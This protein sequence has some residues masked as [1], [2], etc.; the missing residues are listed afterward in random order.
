MKITGIVVEYNPF[1]NG[2][3]YQIERAR[4]L[5][6]CDYLIVVMSGNFAQR[7]IP[8]IT[9]K[10][11]RTEMALACGVDMVLELPVPFATASA[12]R[13]CE[14]A[15][16]LLHKT[17]IVDTLCFGAEIADLPLMETIASL[18][19]DEPPALSEAIQVHLRSGISY[20]RARVM[21]IESYLGKHTQYDPHTIHSVLTSPNNILGIEYLKALRK[22]QS[23]IRPLA[24]QRVA[25]QYHDTEITSTIASAT[26][27]RK[28]YSDAKEDLI[29]TAMPDAAYTLLAKHHKTAAHLDALTQSLLYKFIFS[30]M[31]D[32]YAIWD[33][34]KHLCHSILNASKTC[35]SI[36][37]IVDTATSKTYSRATVQRSILRIL[38]DL[39]SASI[40][41]LEEVGWIPYIRILGCRKTALELISFM[42]KHAKSP[43]ITNPRKALK[44]LDPLSTQLLDHEFKATHLYALLAAR[45][46]VEIHD[47]AKG[48]LV[49]NL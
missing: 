46:V 14:A 38:L 37:E 22:Y 12:E 21:A 39:K 4:A 10:F 31:D 32:L 2:H 5:T 30:N 47:F 49:K 43:I 11:A 41:P 40:A 35:S 26:A 18:M 42:H 9:D 6:Q 1:H 45:P 23:T 36:S 29:Q 8:C 27:I 19:H 28:A 44:N 13:F 17:G 25:S 34:P 15:I 3:L 20:P 16:S 24:I 33:V 48:L 7:G